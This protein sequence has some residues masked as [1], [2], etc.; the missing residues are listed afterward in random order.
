MET[1]GTSNFTKQ[2]QDMADKAAGKI[3]GGIRDVQRA[4]ETAGQQLSTKVES[5]RT[6]AAPMLKNVTDQVRSV[7][8]Q[9]I[10]SVTAAAQQVRD[11]AKQASDTV[12]SYTKA[13][14][15]KAVLIAAATGALLL[16][17]VQAIA[18]ARD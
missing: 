4:S 16:T 7:A 12:V 6:E 5:L 18:R 2:G 8:Q 13:N 10:D 9:G 15:V 14:P 11:S 3:Q 1:T 17:A